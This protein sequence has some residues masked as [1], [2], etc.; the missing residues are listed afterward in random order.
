MLPNPMLGTGPVLP[1]VYGDQLDDAG[2]PTRE[3][4]RQENKAFMQ[5]AG[6]Y[7]DNIEAMLNY[8]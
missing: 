3:V 2:R 4:V 1:S 6:K 5:M 7:L 8:G